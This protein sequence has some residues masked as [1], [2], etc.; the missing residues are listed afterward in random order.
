MNASST[1]MQDPATS[2]V[3]V[4]THPVNSDT[5]GLLQRLKTNRVMC[6]GPRPSR[7][8]QHDPLSG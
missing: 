5:R 3:V 2:W 1:Y 7:H 4:P 8:S 6:I